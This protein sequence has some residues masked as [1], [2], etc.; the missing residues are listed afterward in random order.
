VRENI[1]LRAG[2][3]HPLAFV[4]PWVAL[5]FL[6]A[7]SEDD[8]IVWG[9]GVGFWAIPLAAIGSSTATAAMVMRRSLPLRV[10]VL[11]GLVGLAGS[12]A[13]LVLGFVGLFAAAE[14]DC[15]GRYECPL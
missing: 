8:D 6:T 9:V 14:I 10:R 12:A 11:V 5:A 15:A 2:L 3:L 4:G 1:W 7:T 13:G